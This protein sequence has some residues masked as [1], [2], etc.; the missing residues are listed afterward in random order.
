MNMG[1]GSNNAGQT[2]TDTELEV[3]VLPQQNDRRFA[4]TVPILAAG[5]AAAHRSLIPKSGEDT[6]GTAD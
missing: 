4:D 5:T 6:V 2:I 1:E 3:E